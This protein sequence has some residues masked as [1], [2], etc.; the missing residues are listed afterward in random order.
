[1]RRAASDLADL[2]AAGSQAGSLVVGRAQARAPRLTGRLA[3][4]IS[5]E[6]RGDEVSIGSPLVYAP[7]QEYGSP[8][9]GIR[10]QP[11]LN[12]SLDESADRIA[13]TYELAV[14]GVVAR[15]EGF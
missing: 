13:T 2:Q 15:I 7:I 4:S 11:Y 5:Y 1:M 10:A 12:P 3:A 14:G 6:A 9:R 8:R